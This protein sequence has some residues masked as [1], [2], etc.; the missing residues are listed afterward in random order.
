[1]ISFREN[2][3]FTKFAV[4]FFILTIFGYWGVDL[5]SEELYIAFSFFLLVI[6][7]VAIFRRAITS[8]FLSVINAKYFR[9]LSDLLVSVGALSLNVVEFRNLALALRFL[10]DL[11]LTYS[12]FFSNYLLQD[13]SVV[14]N[15]AWVKSALFRAILPLSGVVFFSSIFRLKKF[16]S[17]IDLRRAN[18]FSISAR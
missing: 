6:L 15:T 14:S 8:T 5:N 13:F 12:R 16:H 9:L 2:F 10:V 11:L 18:F 7:S 1:M 3:F 17:F 4:L